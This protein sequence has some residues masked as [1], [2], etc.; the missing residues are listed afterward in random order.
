MAFVDKE[1]GKMAYRDQP[2]AR[3]STHTSPSGNFTIEPT[4]WHYYLWLMGPC[5]ED[6]PSQK[7]TFYYLRV[8]AEGYQSKLMYVRDREIPTFTKGANLPEYDNLNFH[9]IHLSKAPN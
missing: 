1:E 8:S 6:F 4:K 9:D 2:M 3:V 5:G 7:N